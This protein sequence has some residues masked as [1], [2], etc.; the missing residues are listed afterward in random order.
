M[1]FIYFD[2]AA[3]TFPK[4]RHVIKTVTEC[5]NK[6][7][8]NPRR[9]FNPLVKNANNN[10]ELTRSRLSNLFG[11]NKNQL[12][13]VP[14]ATYAINIVIQGMDVSPSET[15]YI[16]P[17]EHNAVLRSVSHIQKEK[18]VNVKVLPI[19]NNYHLNI[20]K[21]QM[22]FAAYP[23]RLVTVTH[24][25]NVTG[26]I[27]PI[28][29]I[30]DIT[31]SF[32]GKVLIDAAQT[33]GIYTPK[34]KKYNYDFLAF[35]SHKGLYG[36][37][38]SGGLIIKDID[39]LPAP[40]IFGGTGINS[41]DKNM[42]DSVPERYESGT[43]P[44]PSIISMLAGIEWIEK[45]GIEKI[46]K[47]INS[48]K[49]SILKGLSNIGVKIYGHTSPHGNI[50]IVSFNIMGYDPQDIDNILDEHKI[51]I[52]S[53]L[54]CAPLAHKNIGSFPNGTIRVSPAYFNT[55]K[56]IKIFLDVIKQ[57]LI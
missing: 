24:A 43:L 7:A 9:G 14:S 28:K 44:L 35:S 21:T 50:G 36:I 11:I 52:R 42:P 22:L 10:L 2:N 57:L 27:L 16:S 39:E 31:H 4:P 8:V 20:E 13:F 15:V 30:I 47:K 38:G 46:R 12:V 34:L 19:D 26:D 17:F 33:V 48:L 55:E 40:I 53:G 54:H 56:D 37:P 3:T 41:E 32:G 6:F 23:P 51:C 49:K 18:K 1:D 29:D 45:T 25:S 5:M